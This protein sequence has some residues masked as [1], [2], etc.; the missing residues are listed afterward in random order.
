MSS[1]QHFP[2]SKKEFKQNPNGFMFGNAIDELYSHIPLRPIRM[3]KVRK[4]SSCEGFG[5]LERVEKFTVGGSVN[6]LEGGQ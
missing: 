4:Q 6:L 2:S 3:K 1:L 5:N